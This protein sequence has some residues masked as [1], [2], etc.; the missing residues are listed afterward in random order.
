[1]KTDAD[2]IRGRERSNSSVDKVIKISKKSHIFVITKDHHIIWMWWSTIALKIFVLYVV[3]WN[4]NAPS[5]M[6]T[7]HSLLFFASFYVRV[8]HVCVCMYASCLYMDDI[9]FEQRNHVICQFLIRYFWTTIRKIILIILYG[10][11][12]IQIWQRLTINRST[13]VYNSPKARDA[14]GV[15]REKWN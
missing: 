9:V 5:C 12:N 1:M 15:I 4:K 13:R 10:S 2:N 3:I 6:S 8:L 14:S 11:T 7:I